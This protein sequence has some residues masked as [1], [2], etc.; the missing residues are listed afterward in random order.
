M[1][2]ELPALLR[3]ADCLVAVSVDGAQAAARSVR[4]RVRV[5][6]GSLMIQA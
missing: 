3:D 4:G 2:A 5:I 1:E 6:A